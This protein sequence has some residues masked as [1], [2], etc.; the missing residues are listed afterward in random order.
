LEGL[1]ALCE[2]KVRVRAR[3][4]DFEVVKKA[5]EEARAEYKENVKSDVEVE[6]DEKEPLPEDS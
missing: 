5:A 4:A 6:V 1:Y 2:A 3:K